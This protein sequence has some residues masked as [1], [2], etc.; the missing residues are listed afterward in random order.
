MV[1][2]QMDESVE[3]G[4][5][6]IFEQIMQDDDDEQELG[7]IKQQRQAE[8]PQL[9]T[10]VD[11]ICHHRKPTESA[12]RIIRDGANQASAL[13]VIEGFDAKQQIRVGAVMASG[14]EEYMTLRYAIEDKKLFVDEND[15]LLAQVLFRLLPSTVIFGILPVGKRRVWV[16]ACDTCGVFGG[17]VHHVVA[18]RPFKIRFLLE[19]EAAA[20]KTALAALAYVLKEYHQD[21]KQAQDAK[22]GTWMLHDVYF[23]ALLEIGIGLAAAIYRFNNRQ[24]QLDKNV[25]LMAA[26]TEKDFDGNYLPS[27]SSQQQQQQKHKVAGS[28][29]NR[30]P[31][32][33][34]SWKQPLFRRHKH[35]RGR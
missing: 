34:P 31:T 33:R 23:A 35:S 3:N 7:Q 10:R 14:N 8:T 11:E 22:V 13:Q 1:Q 26:P 4:E 28:G 2:L 32:G 6:N 25:I 18:T 19:H 15:R 12:Q 27:S 24:Q 21:Y 30:F 17:Q 5:K 16:Y 20:T 9:V 29:Y